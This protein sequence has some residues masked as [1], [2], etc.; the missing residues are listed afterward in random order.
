MEL[1]NSRKIEFRHFSSPSASFALCP[2]V[3]REGHAAQV[4]VGGWIID[5][6]LPVQFALNLEVRVVLHPCKTYRHHRRGVVYLRDTRDRGLSSSIN[7][8][9]CIIF[10]RS[11]LSRVW[12]SRSM[13]NTWVQRSFGEKTGFLPKLLEVLSVKKVLHFLFQCHFFPKLWCTYF[14]LTAQV[15]LMGVPWPGK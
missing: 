15:T 6:A 9:S 8:I 1:H 5:D 10:Y 4:A 13:D 12:A 2:D 11:G 7:N 3:Q 14:T